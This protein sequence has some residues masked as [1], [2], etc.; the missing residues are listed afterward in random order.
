MHPIG[1]EVGRTPREFAAV[2]VKMCP[3]RLLQSGIGMS[4][5][6]NTTAR[7]LG[8]G[9]AED[10]E[11]RERIVR[12]ARAL[13]LE[14][15]YDGTTMSELAKRSGVTTPALYWHFES[16]AD[17][18]AECLQRDFGRFVA[19]LIERSV[20]ETPE[21]QL[22]AYIATYVELQIQDREAESSVG[23]AQVRHRVSEEARASVKAFEVETV[24]ILK[25]IL[26]AGIDAGAFEIPDLT[27]ATFALINTCEY[28]YTWFRPDGRLSPQEI[29]ALYADLAVN[30]VQAPRA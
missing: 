22:R 19:G 23:Y 8:R 26:R 12:E 10:N 24:E 13:F 2:R 14:R 20:G 25:R 27:L 9:R 5:T 21:A 3:V 7:K 28:V 29:G 15:G 17:I 4:A 16:K 1:Q 30:L 18:G 6:S 11:T